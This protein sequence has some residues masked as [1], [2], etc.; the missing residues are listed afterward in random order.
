MTEFSIKTTINGQ[1]YTDEQLER[2][3]YE[4]ALHVLHEFKRLGIKLSDDNGHEYTDVD[5]NWLAPDKAIRLLEKTHARLGAQKTLEIMKPI[6]EDSANRWRQFNQRPIDEQGCWLNSTHFD[7]K[8][9]T[10]PEIQQTLAT[11]QNGD[12]P[13]KIMPEHYGVAGS[14]TEGQTIMET[15]GCFGEPVVTKGTGSQKIPAYTNMKHHEDYPLILA[16]E[17]HLA[18]TNENIHVGAIHEFKPNNDGVEII[19]TFFCPKDAPQA[20]AQ[21]HAIHFA[22]EM[23]GALKLVAT[24]KNK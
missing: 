12:V 1:L 6:F 23:G 15:F 13:Y 11:I 24:A 10:M 19:S 21:G 3:K 7:V 2:L 4:R 16:G 17:V 20:I 5:L 18:D 9:L 22:L 8:G 14:I